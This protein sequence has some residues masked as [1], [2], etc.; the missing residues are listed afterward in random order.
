MTK[1]I[2][3]LLVRLSTSPPISHSTPG[4]K[5]PMP[6][7]TSAR[8]SALCLFKFTSLL[9]DIINV[10]SII[11]LLEK[12]R[13]KRPQLDDVLNHKWFSEGEFAEIHKLR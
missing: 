5:Y 9:C 8:V 6:A 2:E 10:L 13:H 1:M 4:R 3:R 11:G 12:S 7:R